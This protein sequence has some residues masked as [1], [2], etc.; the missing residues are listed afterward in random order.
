MKVYEKPGESHPFTAPSGG[1]VAGSAY[2]IGS[3]VVVAEVS[4]ASGVLFNGFIGPGIV[5]VAKTTA[6]QWTEGMKVYWDNS[7]RVFTSNTTGNTLVGFAATAAVTT[8]VLG[9]VRLDGVAR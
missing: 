9:K 4:A 8:A 6:T 2:L 1:V 3:I 7:A 5:E